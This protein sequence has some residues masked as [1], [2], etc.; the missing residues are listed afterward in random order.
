METKKV[1][2][3]RDLVVWQ[4]SHELVM[5]MFALTDKFPRRE[6]PLMAQKIRDLAVQIP[7]NVAMGFEKR[8][9]KIKLYHY[10]TALTITEQLGYYFILAQDLRYIKSSTEVLTEL[11]NVE[12]KLKGLLRSVAGGKEK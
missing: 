9:H 12:K 8:N 10:R 6:R 7:S 1:E 3:F 5:K 2:S 11:D 4:M